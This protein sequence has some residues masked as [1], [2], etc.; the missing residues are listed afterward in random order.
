MEKPTDGKSS[1]IKAARILTYLIYGFVMFAIVFLVLGFVLLLFGA[2]TSSSFVTFVYNIAAEFLAP[3]RGIFPPHQINDRSYFSTAGL[4][5]IIMYGIFAMALH[6]L[7]DYITVK[8]VQHQNQLI[9]AKEYQE[10]QAE[11]AKAE[12]LAAE[13]AAAR[14]SQPTRRAAPTQRRV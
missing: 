7:I 4:F 8:Q 13:Q 6:S 2:S 1:F 3:F 5:A 9:E 12:K 11:K 10:E 14:K